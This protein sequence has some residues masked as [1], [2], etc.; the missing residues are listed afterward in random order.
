MLARSVFTSVVALSLSS[1]VFAAPKI[2][3]P[4][5]A[6]SLKDEAGKEHSL[7]AY[8]GKVVVLEW[9]NQG[10]PWVVG[11]YER[12]TMTDLAAKLG[13]K[14]VVWLAVNSTS[15]NK[16][17]DTNSWKSKNAISFPTLMDPEGTVG[18][19]YEAQTTPHMYVVDK[20]GKLAYAGAI[21]DDP[22]NE[23]P[24]RINYVDAAV[25]ALLA[26]KAPEKTETKPYGCSVKYKK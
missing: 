10:C 5:P 9:T 19:A 13:G 3:A 2:G 8:K 24:K 12:K 20:D 15:S 18:K 7:A 1:A 25:S 26:G 6:F 16:P 17:E 14:D 22:G 23:N 21:D 11:H 4:A